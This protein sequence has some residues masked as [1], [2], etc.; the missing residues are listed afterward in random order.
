MSA[1]ATCT[2][3]HTYVGIGIEKKKDQYY[4]FLIQKYKLS[5]KKNNTN[6]GKHTQHEHVHEAQ[7]RRISIL[8][9]VIQS[10]KLFYKEE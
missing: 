4:V 1:F 7:H 5:Y 3:A 9:F 6:M 8:L 2:L 10:D